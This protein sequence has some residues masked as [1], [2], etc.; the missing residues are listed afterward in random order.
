M[1]QYGT[2]EVN[3]VILYMKDVRIVIIFFLDIFIDH[4]ETTITKVLIEEA[5]S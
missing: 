1:P 5:L 3:I 4:N 2:L